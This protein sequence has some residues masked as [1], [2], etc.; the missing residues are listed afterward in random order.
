MAEVAFAKTF[1]STLDARP[2]R[3]S[4]DHVESPRNYPGRPAY[5]LP[6]MPKAMSQPTNLAPGQERSVTVTI[7]S[8]RN[9]PLNIKLASQPMSTSLLD[10]KSNVS[11][12]TRIP[13]DKLKILHN[14]RPLTDSKILKDVLAESETAVEFSVM[15]IGGAAAI[16]P[17]NAAS[18]A[19]AVALTGVAAV[20][21]D[22]F[23]TDLKAFLTQ[24]LKDETAAEHLSSLF[25]SGWESSKSTQ[26]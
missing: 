8:L 22:A 9:P 23:W 1:L 6:R 26:S 14:K 2:S 24:R 13:V 17:E 7:K 3:L 20:E 21:T 25:R 12:Q 18:S 5:I 19:A 10:I 16:V 11:S 4:A 15:V